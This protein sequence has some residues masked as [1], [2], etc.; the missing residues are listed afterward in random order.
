MFWNCLSDSMEHILH[1]THAVRTQPKG[2]DV[3]CTQS[4]YGASSESVPIP[5]N[6]LLTAHEQ[7]P[8]TQ[9][10][11]TATNF[12]DKVVTHL[13]SVHT[14]T[15][16][17]L[18]AAFRSH[19]PRAWAKHLPPAI[20]AESWQH[21]QARS[22]GA[23]AGRSGSLFVAGRNCVQVKSVELGSQL[24]QRPEHAQYGKWAVSTTWTQFCYHHYLWPADHTL[25]N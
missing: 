2:L 25:P 21:C 24:A 17:P 12:M 18:W 7:V 14:R 10:A 19:D 20:T 15:Q 8:A 3:T 23:S 11:V 4:V 9:A 16:S 22:S 13:T 5:H 6:C 1:R